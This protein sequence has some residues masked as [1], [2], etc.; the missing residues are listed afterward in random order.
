MTTALSDSGAVSF[1]PVLGGIILAVA[2][3]FFLFTAVDGMALPTHTGRAAVVG[4]Q[5]R[6][7]GKTYTREVVGN[8]TLNVPHATAEMFVLDLDLEGR[9]VQSTTHRGLHEALAA[10]D[11]VQ[12]T[13]QQRRITGRLQVLSVSR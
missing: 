2:A 13:Y 4:K 11:Q 12:V 7:A 9:H 5:Y 1:M 6:P 8:Q 3:I 10:G